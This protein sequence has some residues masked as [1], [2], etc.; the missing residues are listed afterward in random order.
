MQV[1]SSASSPEFSRSTAHRMSPRDLLFSA[2][3]RVKSPVV[4][5]IQKTSKALGE[6]GRETGHRESLLPVRGNPA[7]CPVVFMPIHR[8]AL[9]FTDGPLDFSDLSLD[10]SSGDHPP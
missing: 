3:S 10:A 4:G 8:M 7:G 1:R 5:S 6:E 2:S 9:A